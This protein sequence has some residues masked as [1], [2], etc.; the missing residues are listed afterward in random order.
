MRKGLA[1]LTMAIRQRRDLSDASQAAAIRPAGLRPALLFFLLGMFGVVPL[2]VLTP[3][4]QVPDEAQH[5]HR[6]YQ[7]SELRVQCIMRDAAAGAILPS[8]LIELTERFLGTRAIHTTRRIT[9]QPFR[10]TWLALDQPL[11]PDRREFVD[12]SG[13]ALYSPLPY[14]PQIIAITVARK[15]GAGSLTMLYLA[16]LANVLVALALLAWAVRIIP[17]GREAVVVAGLL[18]MAAFEYASVSPDAAII[19][20]AFLF[21]AVALRGQL[22][23]RWT[24]GDVAVAATSGLVF[25]SLKP[26]Y[27]PLLVLALPAALT[28]G[29]MKHT[30]SVHAVI[31]VVALGGTA[32]WLRFASSVLVLP[33]PG[34]SLWDQADHIVANPLAYAKTIARSFWYYGNSYYQSLIGVL[35]WQTL[36]LPSF[37]YVLPTGA[38]L[39]SI[40]TQPRN[41]LRLPAYA[42]AW[43]AIL[44]AASVFLIMTWMYLYRTQVGWW[45]VVGVQGRYFLP[46][47]ALAAA[48][49]CSIVR[50][51]PSRRT[52]QAAFVVVTVIIATELLTANLAIIRA[53]G[54]F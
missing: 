44:L 43:N 2:V 50:L 13:A 7:L 9:A 49:A 1:Q 47:L 18:P 24:A 22:R 30:L 3:P 36:Y 51:Q 48:T 54:V 29:R 45:V 11:D 28:R 31:L 46:V 15:A 37:A 4:F 10:S 34:T 19:G 6:A 8:S 33:F 39:L 53:Y 27:A 16:R 25:C 21:T 38:V 32:I 14:L 23:G 26:V 52:S 12:F 17:I 20:T 41:A 5:F 42:V 40:L 35:G